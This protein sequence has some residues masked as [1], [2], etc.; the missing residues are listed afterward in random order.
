MKE[1]VDDLTKGRSDKNEEKDKELETQVQYLKKL[2]KEFQQ[3]ER[4]KALQRVVRN[5]G[6]RLMAAVHLDRA[7]LLTVPKPSLTAA[8][9]RANFPDS[10]T[11]VH[12][13]SRAKDP[14]PHPRTRR[15]SGLRLDTDDIIKPI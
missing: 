13:L 5:E 12:H 11:R 4:R 2:I 14:L 15:P 7:P 8:G 3:K 10:R 6:A 9:A 1:K